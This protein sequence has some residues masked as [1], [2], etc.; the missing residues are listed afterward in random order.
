[1]TTRHRTKSAKGLLTSLTAGASAHEDQAPVQRDERVLDPQPADP[2]P[3]EAPPPPDGKAPLPP[4]VSE[5]GDAD[6][7]EASFNDQEPA[8]PNVEPADPPPQQHPTEH[9]P[10]Q[11]GKEPLPDGENHFEGDEDFEEEE[12]EEAEPVFSEQDRADLPVLEGKVK[13][14]GLEEAKAIREIRQRKL[15]MLHRSEDG[16]RR[17]RSYDEYIQEFH[18]HSRQWAT[19]QT[20]WLTKNETLAALRMKGVDV[21]EVLTRTAVSGLHHLV[22]CGN[23]QGDTEDEQE[24]AGLIAVLQ[25]AAQDGV[26]FSGQILRA[27]CNRRY[28]F[29][30][31]HRWRPKPLAPTYDD[32]KR[33]LALVEPL[34]KVDRSERNNATIKEWAEDN[35]ATMQEAVMA[36]Y[37]KNCS[38]PDDDLLLSIA[39]GD[40]LNKLVDDLVALGDKIAS[41]KEAEEVAKDKREQARQVRE[42]LGLP[43]KKKA[44]GGKSKR[45][46][47]A[48]SSPGSDS[49]GDEDAGEDV[50]ENLESA[51][52]YL[53]AALE[54][55]WPE[56]GDTIQSI[57]EAAQACEGKLAEVVNKAKELLADKPVLAE[58]PQNALPHD[59]H[60]DD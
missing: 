14:H 28:H 51:L 36:T 19:E 31:H 18:G 54:A 47:A 49:D 20:Q 1:M 41:L 5:Q 7:A 39:T 43:T 12:D 60:F 26:S 11:T 58:K 37:K 33:D 23:Y 4:D 53:D 25:E 59:P 17:Y 8:V 57:L 55:E 38:L 16:T 6:K 46:T 29:Y 13:H 45:P 2:Q 44:T 27:I 15:W 48:S 42:S 22:E 3:A 34:G 30:S 56:D 24:E 52:D 9:A 10:E 50:Q 32:Y 35:N 21:P 40:D